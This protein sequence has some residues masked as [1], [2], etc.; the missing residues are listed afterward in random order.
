MGFSMTKG[1][2]TEAAGSNLEIR[3]E[4]KD[5]SRFPHCAQLNFPLSLSLSF[6]LSFKLPSIQSPKHGRLSLFSMIKC[7]LVTVVILHVSKN[8]AQSR[9]ILQNAQL[10]I[11]L[12]KSRRLWNLVRMKWTRT[13]CLISIV[14]LS[15]TQCEW[16]PWE[17]PQL[18]QTLTKQSEGNKC[19]KHAVPTKM[20]SVHDYG[21]LSAPTGMPTQK[22]R[23]PI[24]LST[25]SCLELVMV[26]ETRRLLCIF[27]SPF[28]QGINMKMLKC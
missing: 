10:D 28:H 20:L 17:F 21:W 23:R 18:A 4:N 6:P 22:W 16:L 2:C 24:A 12:D 13:H 8:K 15:C 5:S 1:M 14:L 19:R 9:L 11:K 26:D 25:R 7:V 27:Q 3:R